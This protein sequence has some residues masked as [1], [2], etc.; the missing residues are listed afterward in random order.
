M[1]AQRSRLCS[2]GLADHERPPLEGPLHWLSGPGQP[3]S[4]G[5]LGQGHRDLAGREPPVRGA[6]PFPPLCAREMG[7][8]CK[9]CG[10]WRSRF[11]ETVLVLQPQCHSLLRVPLDVPPSPGSCSQWGPPPA[12]PWGRTG[13]PG[14]GQQVWVPMGRKSLRTRPVLGWAPPRDAQKPRPL[15]KQPASHPSCQRRPEPTSCLPQRAPWLTV[16]TLPPASDLASTQK[17]PSCPA[18]PS[19]SLQ[20]LAAPHLP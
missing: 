6:V 13:R 9:P 12:S 5:P 15:G 20:W 8:R 3:A 4:A 18:A 2:L 14:Q 1:S 16:H 11:R 19:K 17:P 7:L 10:A